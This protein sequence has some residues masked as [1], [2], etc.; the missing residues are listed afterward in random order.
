MIGILF[1]FL[2]LVRFLFLYLLF[3]SIVISFMSFQFFFFFSHSTI[4]P[5]ASPFLLVH[6]I[7]I[8]PFFFCDFLHPFVYSNFFHSSFHHVI[9]SRSFN[10]THNSFFPF[11]SSFVLLSFC[12]SLVENITSFFTLSMFSFSSSSEQ[13][14]TSQS[15]KEREGATTSVTASVDLLERHLIS[16][17]VYRLKNRNYFFQMNIKISFSSD[18]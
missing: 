11:T 16:V 1:S 7:Y 3:N 15:S 4:S 5:S 12:C 18:I 17:E 8:F 13:S 6:L 14:V 2:F 9:F 10:S